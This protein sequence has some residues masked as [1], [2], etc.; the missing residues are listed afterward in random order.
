MRGNVMLLHYIDNKTCGAVLETMQ[1]LHGIGDG[2]ISVVLL[3]AE[4]TSSKTLSK[5]V[6]CWCE[7]M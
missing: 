3:A 5:N 6:P 7:Y 1:K 2:C 4:S